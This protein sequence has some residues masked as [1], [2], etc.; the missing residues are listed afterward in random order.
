MPDFPT[1]RIPPGMLFVIGDNPPESED[2]RF[3]G[4]FPRKRF[5]AG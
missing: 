5:K 4:P 3:F 1:Q 2:S